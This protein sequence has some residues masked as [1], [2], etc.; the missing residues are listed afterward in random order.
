MAHK[1]QSG[2]LLNQFL[3]RCILKSELKADLKRFLKDFLFCTFAQ[4][5][6]DYLE[7]NSK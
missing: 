1:P 6:I 2:F 3:C 7:Y 5:I 4:L